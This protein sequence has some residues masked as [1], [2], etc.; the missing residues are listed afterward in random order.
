[1]LWKSALYHFPA[2][3][4]SFRIDFWAFV[5]STQLKKYNCVLGNLCINV[6]IRT[7]CNQQLYMKSLDHFAEITMS[8]CI[9]Q[10]PGE[11]WRIFLFEQS[12]FA[13]KLFYCLLGDIELPKD[14]KSNTKERKA[15][16]YMYSLWGDLKSGILEEV[17]TKASI[18]D[19]PLINT[20]IGATTK[21][22]KQGNSVEIM[23]EKRC[24]ILDRLKG[25]KDR[26]DLAVK[27]L[28]KYIG[29]V[30]EQKNT[31]QYYMQVQHIE[32]IS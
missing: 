32:N 5:E 2:S 27:S 4:M 12:K 25:L 1:M 19:L 24:E 26:Q 20:V 22:R 16:N 15:R 8:F 30:Q 21:K 31:V 23:K 13:L 14:P 18:R 3:T 6:D 7:K 10:T 11:Q 9:D 28:D 29:L 17:G